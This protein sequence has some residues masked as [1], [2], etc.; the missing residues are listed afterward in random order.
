MPRA[1][2]VAVRAHRCY[3]S[4]RISLGRGGMAAQT[5][6][7]DRTDAAGGPAAIGR[8]DGL[9]FFT[10]IIWGATIPL[11][12]PIVD[13]VDPL[14]F[15]TA[16]FALI[17]ICLMACAK[18]GG[19][20]LRL[21]AADVLPL[22]GL[23]FLGFGLAQSINGVA[24]SL[25][26]ASKGAVLSA[27]IPAFGA[28]FGWMRGERSTIAL[29]IGIVLASAGI[30][31]VINNSVTHWNIG[32][33]SLAGDLLFLLMSA[34]FALYT[35]LSRTALVRLGPVKAGAYLTLF[36]AITML[37]LGFY[38]AWHGAILPDRAY[39]WANFAFVVL[40]S[41]T[42]G[43]MTWYSAVVKLGASRT[44][45]YFYLVPVFALLGSVLFLREP[46]SAIQIVG[47]VLVLGG[48]V[49]A[50]RGVAPVAPPIP[51]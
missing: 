9:A 27:T 35:A 29:W 2:A 41:G 30:I 24:L 48:V 46:F 51:E 12:K 44:L 40:I 6:T 11:S 45:V 5:D 15:A 26:A 20:S 19:Q 36:G 8:G 38:G 34:L 39:L 13:V 1:C 49:V 21:K 14:V 17:A 3:C 42:I 7:R 16:R 10:A 4:A 22:I 18:M 33:G 31:L 32:H 47:S 43:F 23:G 37:P 25:T 28:L 50:R